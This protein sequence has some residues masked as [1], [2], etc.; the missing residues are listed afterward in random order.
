MRAVEVVG[1]GGYGVIIVQALWFI[2]IT[3]YWNYV[4]KEDPTINVR[5]CFVDRQKLFQMTGTTTAFA[6][7]EILVYFSF[8][9]TIVFLTARS[10][11]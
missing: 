4:S 9:S 10:R 7:I 3:D 2:S 6:R 11:C 1:I 5:Q 8:A